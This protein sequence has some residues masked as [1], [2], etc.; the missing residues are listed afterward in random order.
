MSVYC[1]EVHERI[2][3]QVEKRRTKCR[4]KKCKWWCG[5]CNKWFCWVETFLE[6]VVL[7]V[8]RTICEVVDGLL[9]LFGLIAGILYAIPIVGRFFREWHSFLKEL[10]WRLIG[11]LGTFADALG[12]EWR[13]RLR[14]NV[15]ILSDSKGPLTTEAALQPFV[16]QARIIYDAFHVRLIVEGIHTETVEPPS[17]VLDVGCD[18]GAL[19]DDFWL[20]GTWFELHAN[21]WETGF[22]GNGRRL[23]GWASPITVFIVRDVDG[24]SGCSLAFLSDYVTLE[25]PSG[26][27]AH[28]LG[29]ACGLIGHAES[30]TNLMYP[31]CGGT[32]LTKW[33]RVW[34]RGSRHV[35]YF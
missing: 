3:R 10:T 17:Y 20:A 1:R 2:E 24:Y 5:C 31:T 11:L 34:L 32:R 16:D 7:W 14:I 21:E 26:C 30:P 19:G 25:S 15:I 6:T 33:Q 13:K 12:W 9:N 4:E 28:E 8:T 29:H 27:L 18:G 23:I 22:E 35:T